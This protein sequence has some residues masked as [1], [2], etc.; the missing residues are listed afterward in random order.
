MI[1]RICRGLVVLPTR[2]CYVCSLLPWHLHPSNVR[3]THSSANPCLPSR[4]LSHPKV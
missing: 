3:K 1:L 4:W 2:S